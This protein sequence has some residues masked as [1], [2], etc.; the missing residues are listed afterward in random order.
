VGFYDGTIMPGGTVSYVNSAY[1]LGQ[2]L[3]LD[4]SQY[5]DIG[6]GQPKGDVVRNGSF[7]LWFKQSAE[8]SQYMMLWGTFNNGVSEGM[9]AGVTASGSLDFGLR[10]GSGQNITWS[11]DNR[12]PISP[13]TWYFYAATWGINTADPNQ[14]EVHVYLNGELVRSGTRPDVGMVSWQYSMV[15]GAGNSRGSVEDNWFGVLDEVK[16]YNYPLTGLEIA[17]EYVAVTGEAVCLNPP[18]SDL[19]GDCRVDMTDLAVLASEWLFDG[20][21]DVPQPL[22]LEGGEVD[23]MRED[24]KLWS[25]RNYVATVWPAPLRG[26]VFVRSSIG[27]AKVQI[28]QTGYLL[29]VTP[30]YGQR[31][32]FSEE[33]ALR[34]AGFARVDIPPF[35]PFK[36]ASKDGDTC[37]VYQ[38][39]VGAGETYVRKHAYGITLWRKDPLPLY[40]IP[41]PVPPPVNMAP[42]PEYADEARMFQGIPSIARAGNGRL[43]ATWYGGGTGEGYLNYIMLVTS[44]DDGHTWSDLKLVIDPDGDGPIRASEPGLWVDPMGRLWLMWNQYPLGLNGPDASLW[45]ITTRDPNSENPTW[46]APR[47]IA[48]P[49]QN[50]FLKPLVMSDGTWLW[51]SFSFYLPI[52]SRPLLSSD[53]GESFVPGGE[54]VILPEKD[55]NYQEYN[56]VELND[57]RLWLTSRTAYGMGESFSSD[58]GRTWT[59]VTPCQIVHVPARH[60]MTRLNSGKLLLVKHGAIDEQVEKRSRLMA[61]V[62]SDEGATWSAGLMLDER[63]GVSYPDGVQAP[64]GTIYIIYDYNRHTDKE[65]LMATFTEEDVMAGQ[66]VSKKA[67]TRVLVNKATGTAP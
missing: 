10:D 40:T 46:S 29:V 58:K 1:S 54:V 65:I 19:T 25:D 15:L 13:E 50:S 3:A 31:G 17:Q 27:S 60:F 12:P 8:P 41:Q 61:F 30:T 66:F 44:G 21:L 39:Q 38:K 52:Y 16:F 14:M 33:A 4:G 49:N 67:R 53:Q 7:S 64:D 35:L 43:W 24:V 34:M 22:P 5:V 51:P 23:V 57:G 26:Q 47:L 36:G 56:V 32:G 62:S 2:A 45:A 55:R 63:V 20:N 18:E 11:Y 37:C 6:Q 9:W 59:H 42:G 48:Y 28:V